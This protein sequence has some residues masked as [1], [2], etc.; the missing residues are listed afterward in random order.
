MPR[1]KSAAIPAAPRK[2]LLDWIETNDGD[3]PGLNRPA[4]SRQAQALHARLNLD[5]QEDS[6]ASLGP[7]QPPAGLHLAPLG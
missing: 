4:C 2:T 5:A 7:L 6:E 1:S 3:Q